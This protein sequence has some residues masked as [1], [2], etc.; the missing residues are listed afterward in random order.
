MIFT[1]QRYD[2][3]VISTNFKDNIL[4]KFHHRLGIA[5]VIRRAK[6]QNATRNDIATER[7]WNYLV[8][9]YL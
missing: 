7:N 1:M 3:F 6:R 5:S 8:D 2:K 4:M 9:S